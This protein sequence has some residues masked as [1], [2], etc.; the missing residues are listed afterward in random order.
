MRCTGHADVDYLVH[1]WMSAY[2]KTRIDSM[3][4][5]HATTHRILFDNPVTHSLSRCHRRLLSGG[6]RHLYVVSG[7]AVRQD[8][9]DGGNGKSMTRKY[10]RTSRE[11]EKTGEIGRWRSFIPG[12][13][14]Y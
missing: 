9:P 1:Y 14:T 7:V 3:D 8:N 4:V 6:P 12:I 2:R 11:S 10:A 5:I 13:L